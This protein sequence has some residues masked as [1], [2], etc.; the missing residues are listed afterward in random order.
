[1]STRAK[2]SACE[3]IR[4]PLVDGLPTRFGFLMP[5]NEKTTCN[6]SVKRLYLDPKSC[7]RGLDAAT[8]L[9]AART[10]A[11]ISLSR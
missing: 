2:N 3:R 8:H 4:T 7:E 11:S 9:E 1:M 5:M 6:R 10:H